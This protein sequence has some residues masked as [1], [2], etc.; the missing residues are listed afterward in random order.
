MGSPC[1]GAMS[2]E[3]E[4]PK[5]WGSVAANWAFSDPAATWRG[6]T[7]WLRLVRRQK[8]LLKQKLTLYQTRWC[9][10]HWWTRKQSYFANHKW[11][12]LATP[13][14]C[15]NRTVKRR[16]P[17]S[18]ASLFPWNVPLRAVSKDFAC[19]RSLML[20]KVNHHIPPDMSTFVQP[21]SIPITAKEDLGESVHRR[22]QTANILSTHVEV[23]HTTPWKEGLNCCLA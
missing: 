14:K 7:C 12:S 13:E 10:F 16:N 22:T 5:L 9:R 17:L 1:F 8:W 11:R 18:P 6:K 15:Q 20:T 23:A 19:T 4:I 3:E 2:H 21:C